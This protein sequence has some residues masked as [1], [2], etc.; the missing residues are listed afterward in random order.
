MANNQDRFVIGLTGSFGSGCSTIR[1]SL[2]KDGFEPFS[3]SKYVK[4]AWHKETGKPIEQAPRKE[5]Q[6]IGDRLREK[7]AKTFYFAELALK[8]AEEK[9]KN[10]TPWVFDSIRNLGE[11]RHFRKRFHNFFLFAVDCSPRNRWERV[12]KHYLDLGLNEDQFEIDDNRDKYDER[13]K[14]GQQVELCVDDADVVID[15][16]KPYPTNIVQIDKLGDKVSPCIS[17][18][19]EELRRPPSPFE[20]YMGMAYTASL[21]SQCMKRRVGAVIVDEKNDAVVSVGYNETPPGIEPCK[22][23]YNRC[24]RD[25]YKI[26]YFERLES[27]GQKCPKCETVLKD[28]KPP[29]LC[30]NCNFDLDRYFISDKALDRCAALHAEEKAILNVGS[31]NIQGYTIYTTTFPCYSCAK[32]IITS[33]LSS[34]VYVEPYPDPDSVDLLSEGKISVRKFEGVK[35]RA[36][37]RVFGRPRRE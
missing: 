29:F 25:I 11:L 4:E 16:D 21:M 10:G 32:K 1:E 20:L 7:N 3:L 33:R 30:R 23:K 9:A 31:R 19:K 5:L 15:N 36:Y 2:G 24:S 28:S 35:A 14:Y 34:V 18:L 13:T 6:D 8:E 27:S 37:F 17:L 12:K 22:I 26:K